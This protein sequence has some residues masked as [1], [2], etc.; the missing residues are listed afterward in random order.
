MDPLKYDE[1]CVRKLG[2]VFHIYIYI[3]TSPTLAY[4]IS[5]ILLPTSKKVDVVFNFEKIFL[6]YVNKSISSSHMVKWLSWPRET[7]VQ[8]DLQRVIK[9]S[10]SSTYLTRLLFQ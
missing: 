3:Y 5:R 8:A 6:G 2:V 10:F 4:A 1:Q 7:C 9:P